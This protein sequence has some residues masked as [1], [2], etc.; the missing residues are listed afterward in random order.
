ALDDSGREPA[1]RPPA[2]SGDHP[3]YVL[4]TSGSTGRPKGVVVNHRAIVNRLFWMQHEYALD[5][6]DVVLQKTPC[7][8]DVSVWEFFW[9]LM[10]GARLVMAPPEAHRDPQALTT[11][12]DDYGV[13]TLHFV[14]SMLAIWVEALNERAPRRAAAS[15]K[16]VFCSGE[17]LSCELASRYQALVS[18]PLHNLYG[19]TEA[20]VDVTYQPASGE[21]LAAVN[22]A[23]VPIG[24]PVWNTQLSILD[25]MLRPVPVGCA[26]DLY[27]RGIQ[28]ADGY[29]HRPELTAQRFVADPAGNGARMYRTGDI[30]RWLEDGSVEYLGR[31][32][33]QLKIRGQRIELGEIEQALLAQPGV[34]QAA[35][36][37]IELSEGATGLGG[38]DM[39]QLVAW[40]IAQPGVTLDTGALHQALE[41]RLPAHMM[42]V[43]Y[44]MTDSFPLSASGK[45]DRK[46]LPRPQL[47]PQSG[48]A[49]HSDSERLLA[50]LFREL[51]GRETVYADDDF[52]A[53]G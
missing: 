44:V 10:V 8:F 29:L 47:N 52:F 38:A 31:S 33:D 53:L 20:A 41:A 3:A 43:S 4:Y 35:V 45:L 40:L 13:T 26:G 36:H 15:L 19:P 34:A 39:R 12:I 28:L 21:A 30:A 25:A 16:R 32:D 37:A 50:A 1:P 18:A 46:A 27:L 14:P 48:R 6:Q 23:G 49:P 22:G 24:K 51:L 5:A 9:P 42:P 17:A 2:G 11:L 7:S